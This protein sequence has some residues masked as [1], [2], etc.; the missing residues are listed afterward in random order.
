M[1]RRRRSASAR[2]NLDHHHPA[3]SGVD[4]IAIRRRRVFDTQFGVYASRL[5]DT[6]E[7][8]EGAATPPEDEGLEPE[9]KARRKK[10][11]EALVERERQVAAEKKSADAARNT[12]A[13]RIKVAEAED[14]YRQMLI[15]HVKQCDLM[16]KVSATTLL[17][18]ECFN[19]TFIVG[20]SQGNTQR[21]T[22]RAVRRRT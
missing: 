17:I 13:E 5:Q 10:E 8:M 12:E 18:N 15:D 19:V 7:P 21:R 9:E 4:M 22:L 2:R 3:R 16:F 20:R 6:D 1:R 11:R 14:I